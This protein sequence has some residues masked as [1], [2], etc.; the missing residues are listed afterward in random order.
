MTAGPLPPAIVLGTG[1]VSLGAITDLAAEGV[2]VVHISG[3]AWDVALRSRRAVEKILL[4]AAAD[5]TDQLLE[6]LLGDDRSWDGACL[7]PT[8]DPMV[9]FVSQHFDQLTQRYVTPVQ[10]WDRLQHVVDKGNLYRMA[11]A[12]G[13]PKP[14]VLPAGEFDRAAEWAAEVGFPLIVKPTET[15]KFFRIFERKA[16][17]A[18][19]LTE[20]LGYLEAVRENGLDVMI[21]EVIPGPPGNL[22]CYR[23]Y[24]NRDG[25]TVAELCSEKIRCYP[26]DYGVGVV[27]KTIPMVPELREFGRRLLEQLQFNGFSA[28]EFKQDDRDGQFKL[29]EINPRPPQIT[30]LF[31][32]A[33]LNFVYLSYLDSLGQPLKDEYPYETGVYGIHNTMDLY[34][35]RGHALQGM[36]GLKRFFAPYL[37]SKKVFLVPVFGDPAP[38]AS[39]LTDMTTTKLRGLLRGL[40]SKGVSTNRSV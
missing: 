32:A 24:V 11:D 21:S 4:D 1:V 10:H 14:R 18:N 38:F 37:A 15:P 34:H 33:G 26:P 27:H 5:P 30:R 20:L 39:I 13:V 12:A 23:S 16:L 19:S 3:K 28:M 40:P 25:R 35:L 8:T 36:A 9:R 22:K 31:R 2:P 7:I 6:V 17:E 29:M